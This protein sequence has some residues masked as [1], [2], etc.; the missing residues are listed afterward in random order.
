MKRK[1]GRPPL[2]PQARLSAPVHLRLALRHYDALCKR[3][4]QARVSVPSLIRAA[5]EAAHFRNQE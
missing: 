5:L 2:D 3:A 1:P 4:A